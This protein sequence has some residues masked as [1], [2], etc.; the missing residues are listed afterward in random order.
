MK[1]FT[2]LCKPLFLLTFILLY[3]STIAQF[4]EEWVAMDILGNDIATDNKGNVYVA[5]LLAGA[6][7][8][9]DFATV[10]YNANGVMQWLS[11]Y[12]GPGNSD[13]QALSLAVDKDGNV[14]V[15]GE[16]QGSGTGYD[17]ATIRYNANGVQLWVARYNGPGNGNDGISNFVRPSVPQRLAVDGFGNVYVTGPSTGAGT[18]YD[19]A[20]I[21]YNS[22]GAQQWVARYNGAA[23]STDAANALAVDKYGNVYV[24]GFSEGIGTGNDYATIR[25]NANGTQ[26]WV[27]RYN[28]PV[29]DLDEARSIAVDVNGNVYVTGRSARGY[30]EDGDIIRPVSNYHTVKYNTAG[31]QQWEALYDVLPESHPKALALD[32]LGNVYVTGQSGGN[33]D[34]EDYATVKYN[35]N[36]DE[37]W[38][39]R[40]TSTDFDHRA[41]D[42]ALDGSGNVYVTGQSD[43]N[44]VT[45]K[46][47]TN[48]EQQW[49][50]K[51]NDL[52]FGAVAFS[53]A[54]DALRNVYVTGHPAT[55]KYSQTLPVC[56][57]KGDKVL[58]CHKGGT[59]CIPGSAAMAHINHGDQLGGCAEQVARIAT[60]P[61][62]G[63]NDL[64][65]RFRVAVAPNPAGGITKISYELPVAGHVT[66]KVFDIVGRQITTL[67]DAHKPAGSHNINLN[68][69]ALMNGMY[70]FRITVKSAK[71]SW[72][73]TGK[74]NVL[75]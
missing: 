23:N 14:F 20:T 73:E 57:N 72:S 70:Y 33:T 65:A 49:V 52:G 39:A 50:A 59:I 22:N 31:V 55:I 15:T 53:I 71:T 35:T 66:I 38:A 63:I 74:I 45:V 61:S 19:Y 12:N 30:Y 24:T 51:G 40:Y 6:G 43:E 32:A 69:T 25:Y 34:E 18:G 64:P 21:K 62:A 58:V 75:R 27:T 60:G 13:D 7:T 1:K 54:V 41:F 67:A 47:N 10:K 44:Y 56:G 46:Y 29:N 26:Q 11:V 9:S 16:S 17:F 68:V 28:G 8:G 48:G 37:Q 36:G 42:L 2:H 5:G 3:T 4:K